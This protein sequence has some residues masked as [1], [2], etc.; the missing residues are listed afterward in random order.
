MKF[1]FIAERVAEFPV[2]AMC[3]VLAVSPSGFYAW[4]KRPLSDRA[5]DDQLLGLEVAAAH[6]TSRGVYGSPRVT[7]ELKAQGRNVSRKRVAR[8]MREAGLRGRKRRPYRA[9]TDS[10]HGRPLPRNLLGRDFH[11]S[12]P[13]RVWVTDVTAVYT[14]TGWLYLAVI[15]DLFSRA[16]VGWATSKHNDTALALTALRQAFVARRPPPGLIHHSDKGAPYA[17]AAYRAHLRAYRMRASM[18]RTG[19]C[20]D[21]AVAESFFASLK[22]E[23]L[24]HDWYLSHAAA[25]RAISDYIDSF[26]NPLRR[27]STIGYLSPD[28]FE[29]R[30]YMAAMVAA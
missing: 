11:S 23:W 14:A 21:N 18:S 30:A 7:A 24:D 29:V 9:T 17:S 5:R 1:D 26:Y 19:D 6:A 13:N 4:R 2:R 22:G 20:W 25:R 3:R 16:V 8:K 15:L 12:R 27:H 28:E 10:R